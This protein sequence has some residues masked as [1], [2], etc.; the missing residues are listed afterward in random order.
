MAMK[1]G[2]IILALRTKGD[3]LLVIHRYPIQPYFK[4]VRKIW[5]V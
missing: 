4:Y 3:N 2:E 5:L 1:Q